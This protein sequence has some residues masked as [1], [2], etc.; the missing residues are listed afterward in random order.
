MIIAIKN[1][2]FKI[3]LFYLFIY[4]YEN[5]DYRFTDFYRLIDIYIAKKEY[6]NYHH[7]EG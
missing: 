4:I 3:S 6:I 2:V 7:I 5:T 1:S